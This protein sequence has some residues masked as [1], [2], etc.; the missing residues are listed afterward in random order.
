MVNVMAEKGLL[1][2]AG[3]LL[4]S[5]GTGLVQRQVYLTGTS[6]IITGASIIFIREYFKGNGRWKK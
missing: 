6:L 2:T 1:A 3:I 4:V 5:V